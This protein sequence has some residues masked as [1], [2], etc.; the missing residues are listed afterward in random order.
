MPNSDA[1]VIIRATSAGPNPSLA[2]S[3]RDRMQVRVEVEIKVKVGV[4]ILG[5]RR[6]TVK[7][8]F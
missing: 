2:W 3:P 7:V 1:P 8:N 4:R 5:P 6:V